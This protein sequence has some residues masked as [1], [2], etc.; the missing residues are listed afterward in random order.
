MALYDVWVMSFSPDAGDPVPG[1]MRTFRLDEE[2]AREL[3]QTVPRIVKRRVPKDKGEKIARALRKLGGEVMVRPARKSSGMIPAVT[4]SELPPPKPRAPAMSVL[5]PE[6]SLVPGASGPPGTSGIPKSTASPRASELPA[7][8]QFPVDSLP[9][10]PA[11]E[12]QEFIPPEESRPDAPV[13]VQALRRRHAATRIAGS[14]S[15]SEPPGGLF[16]PQRSSSA[17]PALTPARPPL[18]KIPA[19]GAL[20]AD[21]APPSMSPDAWELDTDRPVGS[22]RPISSGPPGASE[23]PKAPVGPAHAASPAPSEAPPREV[24]VVVPT[25]SPNA[26]MAMELD[27]PVR[28][29]TP[30]AGTPVARTGTPAAGTP[31][32]PAMGRVG[33]PAAGSPIGSMA[34]G[35][36]P[37]SPPSSREWIGAGLLFAVGALFTGIRIWRG[38]SI[39]YGNGGWF[40]GAW[41]D[42]TLLAAMVVGGWRIFAVLALDHDTEL[43]ADT[44]KRMA[45]LVFPLA[46]AINWWGPFEAKV[47]LTGLGGTVDQRIAAMGG[48]A[49]ACLDTA[50]TDESCAD[51]C[52]TQ[53]EMDDGDC[54][55]DV[56]FRCLE[57]QTSIEECRACC[58]KELGR[59]AR[60]IVFTSEQGCICDAYR[61]LIE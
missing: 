6:E 26:P 61:E 28:Q 40:L 54:L 46:L 47:D 34:P 8:S 33:T 55:C 11:E 41:L 44:S 56:P 18:P 10:G 13:P 32:A 20:P 9:P 22:G 45:W 35:S 49:D 14:S 53:Y 21:E 1:L 29:R 42:A 23:K 31:V 43:A 57:G 30:P 2:K 15:R 5:A 7:S 52:D 4:G 16:R 59:A 38:Q 17:P 37:A 27:S 48:K 19:P 24:P 12:P 39:F 60:G 51:C 36:M 3:E 50:L 25:T 58:Q